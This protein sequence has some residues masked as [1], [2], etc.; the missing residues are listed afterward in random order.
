MQSHSLIKNQLVHDARAKLK[1][2]QTIAQQSRQT[3]PFKL[4]VWLRSPESDPAGSVNIRVCLVALKQVVRSIHS[5]NLGSVLSQEIDDGAEGGDGYVVVQLQVVDATG[6]AVLSGIGSALLHRRLPQVDFEAGSE[7]QP[8]EAVRVGE[9]VQALEAVDTQPDPL[10]QHHDF[11]AKSALDAL[12]L[13][14]GVGNFGSNG[15]TVGEHPF[16]E[17]DM[18]TSGMLV[19]SSI[20]IE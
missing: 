3:T 4:Q 9:S 20:F 8:S 1:L 5:G 13:D 11:L 7:V 18:D 10:P 15:D 6:P 14:G 12:L 19:R 16:M 2:P 17:G